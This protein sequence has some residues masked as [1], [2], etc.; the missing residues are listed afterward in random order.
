MG[1]GISKGPNWVTS[2]N[3]AQPSAITNSVFHHRHLLNLVKPQEKSVLMPDDAEIPPGPPR[4]EAAG[5][6]SKV[7]VAGGRVE[8]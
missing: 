2:K 1:R 3:T 4:W 8:T 7:G 5:L 6:P